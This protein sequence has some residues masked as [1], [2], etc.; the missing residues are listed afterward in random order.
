MSSITQGW[1]CLVCGIAWLAVL[2]MAGDARAQT[3]ALTLYRTQFESSE[4]FSINSDLAGQ[5]GWVNYYTGGNGVF[6]YDTNYGQSAYIGYLPAATE[7]GLYLSRAVSFNPTNRS[8]VTFTVD[9][10]VTGSSSNHPNYDEFRWSVYNLN[11]VR[12]FSLGVDN[13]DYDPNSQTVA[14]YYQ[15]DD[16]A[17]YTTGWGIFNDQFYPL[18]I[19]MNFAGN[20]WNAWLYDTLVVTNAL[21]TTTNA[22]K[23]L[24]S[25]DAVWLPNLAG[26]GDNYMVFDNYS[27]V[28]D[29]LPARVESPRLLAGGQFAFRVSGQSGMR[30][31]VEAS[32]NLLNWVALQTNLMT[33]TGYFDY[34]NAPG[35]LK[36]RFYRTR[37][38]P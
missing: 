30:Y 27:L 31:A 16:G 22:A 12:L 10:A 21:I 15:L 32:T 17:F 2:T 20:R 29:T 9:M 5:N 14:L 25:V 26:A 18:K 13:A 24:S 1:R 23:N 33:T 36:Q 3:S 11:Q 38:I 35:S 19:E 28:A 4:G 8:V 34:T 7:N 6:V 37:W